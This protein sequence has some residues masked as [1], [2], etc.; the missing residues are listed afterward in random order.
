MRR[1]LS[2]GLRRLARWQR[3]LR[4]SMGP[5]RNCLLVGTTWVITISGAAGKI[6]IIATDECQPND[7]ACLNGQSNHPLAGWKFLLPPYPGGVTLLLVDKT[8]NR[9]VVNVAGHQIAFSLSTKNF[10]DL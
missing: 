5:L 4:S 2:P 3:P 6:G 1:K 9:V 8:H 10:Q 7:G